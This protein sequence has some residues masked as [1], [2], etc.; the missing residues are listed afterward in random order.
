V[1][2]TPRHTVAPT[3][4]NAVSCSGFRPSSPATVAA[5]RDALTAAGVEAVVRQS[6][7]G[8]IDAACGQLAGRTR[9]LRHDGPT[10]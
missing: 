2:R 5:F 4:S 9:R 8:G 3:E 6:K 1:R 10:K 7:G